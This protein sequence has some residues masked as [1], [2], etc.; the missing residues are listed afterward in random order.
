M[1]ETISTERRHRCP[2]QEQMSYLKNASVR[3]KTFRHWPVTARIFKE[4]L[5]EAGFFY[6]NDRDRVQ[7]AFCLVVIGDWQYGDDAMTQHRRQNP[8]CPFA[9]GLPVGNVTLTAAASNVNGSR[10]FHRSFDRRRGDV[11]IRTTAEPEKGYGYR[12]SSAD[13]KFWTTVTTT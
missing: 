10:L 12:I 1:A 9:L 6:F 11:E 13:G 4:S 2:T 7:C 3:L 8:R 5:A